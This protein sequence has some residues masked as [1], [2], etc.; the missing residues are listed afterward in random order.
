MFFDRSSMV[1]LWALFFVLLCTLHGCDAS[2]RVVDIGTEY[3]SRPDKYVGLQMKTGI[4]YGARLQS[5][6]GDPHL[7]GGQDFNVTVPDDG[8]PGMFDCV[9]LLGRVS[10][11]LLPTCIEWNFV[12]TLVLEFYLYLYV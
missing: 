3:L 4:E 6:P 12:L 2:I 8:R 10:S 5:I 7:C 1:S 9:S 11:N